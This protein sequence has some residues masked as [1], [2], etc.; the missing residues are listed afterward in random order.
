MRTASANPMGHAPRGSDMV[1]LS[2]GMDPVV[3]PR[4]LSHEL[5]HQYLEQND[6][7]RSALGKARKQD[8]E[9]QDDGAREQ[10]HYFGESD[11]EGGAEALSALLVPGKDVEGFVRAFPR[12]MKVAR[13]CL[14]M[15]ADDANNEAS[16]R[17]LREA[18]K[19]AT[20]VERAAIARKLRQLAGNT[21]ASDAA[22]SAKLRSTVQGKNKNW[23]EEFD[24]P[25]EASAL[26]KLKVLYP[27]ATIV[28][29]EKVSNDSASDAAEYKNKNTWEAAVK[30]KYPGVSIKWDGDRTSTAIVDGKEVG[31][32]NY[33]D[34][35]G[36]NL[37][38]GT[39]WI[40]SSASDMALDREPSHR[41]IDDDGRLHVDDSNIAKAQVDSYY[42][43][44]IPNWEKLGLQPRRK[45]KMLRDPEE[46]E[47][48][49]D[50]FK[51]VPIL[52]RHTPTS[53]E[54]H[55]KDL[56]IGAVGSDVR[57][58]A[59]HLKSGLT[60]WPAD[61]IEDILNDEKRELSP[62]YHYTADMTPGSYEGEPYDGVMR[63]IT[64]NHVALVE[65]GRQ[66]DS[67]AVNDSADELLWRRLED[68][69]LQLD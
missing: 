41:R 48:A 67:V 37:M 47:K 56:T 36:G 17:L 25:D 42:G 45:Y 39:G 22:F 32:F 12:M 44:E 24:A 28:S 61:D 14:G 7:L 46:L 69:I 53:A 62:S 2:D 49:A 50:S 43:E 15:T 19:T 40:E 27:D 54:D 38:R 59:P 1:S 4:V 63:S 6:E 11:D 52:S 18:L 30:A 34:I 31:R 8:V 23:T 58:D 60:F 21:N 29:I 66:G 68:A 55:P 65:K 57:W 35:R 5:A 13:D 20:P 64:G 51:G 16:V 26:R 3:V 33:G 10:Y 9:A